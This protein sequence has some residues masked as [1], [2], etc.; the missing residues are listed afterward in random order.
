[1][2]LVKELLEGLEVVDFSVGM[3]GALA[4]DSLWT[5]ARVAKGGTVWQA[6]VL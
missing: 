1:M 6:T 3:A 5:R 4:T 2:K